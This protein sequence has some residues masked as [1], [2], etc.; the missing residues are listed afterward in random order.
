VLFTALGL[1]DSDA[2]AGDPYPEQLHAAV[3][4]ITRTLGIPP[5]LSYLEAG[6]PGPSSG[7]LLK[8]LRGEGVDR[9][10]FCPLGT[11]LDELEVLHG[12]EVRLRPL[13]KTLG[14]SQVERAASAADS[15]LYVD[16]LAAGLQEHLTRVDSLGFVG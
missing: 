1:D 3:E 4:A 12:L 5:R 10:V 13:A 14:Y 6:G 9:V 8:H 11:T 2:K 15:S 7:E 16:A